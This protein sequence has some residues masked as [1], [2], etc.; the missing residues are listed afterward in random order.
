MLEYVRLID[1]RT[2]VT[3]LYNNYQACVT[4]R[5]TAYVVMFTGCHRGDSER[6]CT[7]V[8]VGERERERERERKRERRVGP[9]VNTWQNGRDSSSIFDKC[10]LKSIQKQFLNR[11]HSMYFWGDY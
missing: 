3:V 1:T 10:I 4:A 9:V 11:A 5:L 6:L 8:W 2:K 7:R